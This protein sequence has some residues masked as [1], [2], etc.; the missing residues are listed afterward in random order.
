MIER[1]D[2]NYDFLK[3][4][5]PEME[6][7]LQNEKYNDGHA[8]LEKYRAVHGDAKWTESGRVVYSYPI[9]LYQALL[10]SRADADTQKKL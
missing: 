3:D 1:R 10:Y 9:A 7:M 2:A 4:K 8:Q 5:I 6:M